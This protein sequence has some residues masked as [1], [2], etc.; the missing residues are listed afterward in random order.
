MF[1][2]VGT[3]WRQPACGKRSKS[4]VGNISHKTPCH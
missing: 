3:T 2:T 1:E 4:N